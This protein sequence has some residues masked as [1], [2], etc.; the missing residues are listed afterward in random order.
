M[1]LWF[2][3]KQWTTDNDIHCELD[4]LSVECISHA[5]AN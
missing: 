3:S 2:H 1:M 4:T 5:N